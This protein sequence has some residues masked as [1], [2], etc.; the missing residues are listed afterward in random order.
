MLKTLFDTEGGRGARQEAPVSAYCGIAKP[1]PQSPAQLLQVLFNIRNDCLDGFPIQTPFFD[2]MIG[3]H[4]FARFHL[5]NDHG[6]LG[7]RMDSHP[8]RSVFESFGHDQCDMVDPVLLAECNCVNIQPIEVVA[9]KV[10]IGANLLIGVLLNHSVNLLDQ[11][12]Q[13]I[14]KRSCENE[15]DETAILSVIPQRRT[16]RVAVF[17]T[18][19]LFDAEIEY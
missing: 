18:A 13:A 4:D 8:F 10:D 7:V 2:G 5:I 9:D 11:T 19:I 3:L 15:D 1:L 6:H 14:V 17:H 12:G 16:N